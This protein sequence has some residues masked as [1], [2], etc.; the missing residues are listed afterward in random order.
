MAVFSVLYGD[1]L[2]R[3]LG[4]ADRTERFTTQRRKD[5][6]NEG[7]DEFIRLTGAFTEDAE[8]TMA[9]QDQEFNLATLFPGDKFLRLHTRQP[10]ISMSDLNASVTYIQG[11]DFPRKDIETLDREE[12]GWRQASAGRPQCWYVREDVNAIYIGIYP[13]ADIPTGHTWTLNVPAV[14]YATALSGDS[15]VPF[16]GKNVLRVYH[17]ALVHYAAAQL[18]KLRRNYTVSAAQLDA[19]LAYVNEYNGDKN[20]TQSGDRVEFGHNYFGSTHSG[21]GTYAPDPRRDDV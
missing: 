9:D 19:F 4:S 5:A 1:R 8:W 21:M 2:D 11:K 13:K 20:K 3:E 17:Q 15:N 16:E 14:V 10:Y 12:P 18:E 7:Q 6:V